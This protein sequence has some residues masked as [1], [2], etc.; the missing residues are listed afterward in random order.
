LR[1][2]VYIGQF[3]YKVELSLDKIKHAGSHESL[4]PRRRRK[5][6][7][8]A[9]AEVSTAARRHHR[10]LRGGALPPHVLVG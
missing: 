5:N 6:S 9:A 3:A 8:A 1:L 7:D 4:T 10:L 2:F